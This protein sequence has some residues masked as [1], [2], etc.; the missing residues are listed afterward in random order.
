MPHFFIWDKVADV[1]M[2]P[3]APEVIEQSGATTASDIWYFDF[4]FMF[5]FSFID[6]HSGVWGAW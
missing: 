6:P 5:P 3:V 2:L 1:F 4:L